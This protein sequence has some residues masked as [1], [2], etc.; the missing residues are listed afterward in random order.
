VSKIPK[1]WRIDPKTLQLFTSVI[2]LGT[3]GGAAQ[4]EH[5]ASSALSKRISD[6]EYLY[7][8]TTRFEEPD[9]GRC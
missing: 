8:L 7:S 4:R 9:L 6:L 2:E 3:I 1:P 5:I